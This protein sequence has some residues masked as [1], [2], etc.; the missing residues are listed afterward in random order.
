MNCKLSTIK[1]RLRFK[2]SD[3]KCGR[4][5]LLRLKRRK[6]LCLDFERG[7][8]SNE[9]DVAGCPIFTVYLK[10]TFRKSLSNTIVFSLL[11]S[12]ITET[13]INTYAIEDEDGQIQKD[14]VKAKRTSGT[15]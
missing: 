12:A 13:G 4:H 5:R 9:S 3:L 2:L 8:R 14:Q 11:S 1:G 10:E 15:L 6:Q 7:Q